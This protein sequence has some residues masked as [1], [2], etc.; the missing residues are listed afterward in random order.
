MVYINELYPEL[1]QVV[2][3][4]TR[5]EMRGKGLMTKLLGALKG[6]YKVRTIVLLGDKDRYNSGFY[7]RRH[8]FKK[9]H[10]IL[11]QKKSPE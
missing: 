1:V 11:L 9:P 4:S 7:R 2:L 8:F 10:N 3:M 5:V 6:S